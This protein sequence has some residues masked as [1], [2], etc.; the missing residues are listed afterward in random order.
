MC[1]CTIGENIFA[2]Q[3]KYLNWK[4]PLKMVEFDK[5]FARALNKKPVISRHCYGSSN[6]NK[7]SR[8]IGGIIIRS[9]AL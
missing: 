3:W 1:E 2:Q 9:T 7:M 8:Y 4:N 5:P 6:D